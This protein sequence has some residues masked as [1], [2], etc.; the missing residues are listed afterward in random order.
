MKFVCPQCGETIK[1]E[2]EKDLVI[3]AQH[4][5]RRDHGAAQ[6]S[7]TREPKMDEDK[8]REIIEKES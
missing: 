5:Y 7:D 1:D 8:I 3:T 4:H 6:T 2:D